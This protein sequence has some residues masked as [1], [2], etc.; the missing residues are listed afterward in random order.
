MSQNKHQNNPHHNCNGN[1]PHHKHERE[2]FVNGAIVHIEKHPTI[3]IPIEEYEM[4]IR[5]SERVE[6]VAGYVLDHHY[7]ND[8]TI[9]RIL[10]VDEPAKGSE[11]S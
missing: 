10:G 11:E 6:I 8:I 5:I 3:T 2:G 9:L 4:L 1:C 7:P